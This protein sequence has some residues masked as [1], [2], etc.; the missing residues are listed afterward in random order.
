MK[1]STKA[2][3]LFDEAYKLAY[4]NGNK[5]DIPW[6][7]IR[8]LWEESAKLGLARSIFYLGTC[9][10]LGLG[11]EKNLHT[12]FDYYL[13]AANLGHRDSQ[14]NVGFF[15]HTGELFEKNEAEKV[16]WYTKAANSGLID[17]QRDLGYAYFYGEGVE[18][19]YSKAI[20]LYKKAARQN[21]SKALYNLAL[22]YKSGHGVIKSLRW[23]KF[24]L[25]KSASLGY[26]KAKNRL[27]ALNR[28]KGY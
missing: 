19:D 15:Y 28:D 13:K 7:K 14:Y 8:G 12:A 20:K 21:D 6:E 5:Q 16:F 3:I 23:T 1:A 27:K 4:S 9:Y 11:I 24:Y 25:E 26:R 17:A 10:D 18:K 2:E 22:C